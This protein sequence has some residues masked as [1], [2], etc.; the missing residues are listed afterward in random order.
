MIIPCGKVNL[1]Q[2]REVSLKERTFTKIHDVKEALYSMFFMLNSAIM[3]DEEVLV[4]LSAFTSTLT[5][6]TT[7]SI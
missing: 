6:Q 5:P 1:I 7:I 2:N 4:E 3:D